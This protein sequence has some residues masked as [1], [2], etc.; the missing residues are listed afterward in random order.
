MAATVT[1]LSKRYGA[2]ELDPSELNSQMLGNLNR[3]MLME[4]EAEQK[5][6]LQN[7]QAM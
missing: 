1:L 6:A 7:I 5:E 4:D 3:M 2:T